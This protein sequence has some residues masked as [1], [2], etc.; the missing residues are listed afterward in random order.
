MGQFLRDQLIRNV[1]IDEAALDGLEQVFR[2]RLIARNQQLFLAAQAAAQG[3]AAGGP[4]TRCSR[5]ASAPGGAAGYCCP[6][7]A[8]ATPRAIS[9][10]DEPT[11]VLALRHPL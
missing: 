7:S 9:T 5:G 3:A 1:T 2:S 8:A 6:T 11:R 4:A 10:I